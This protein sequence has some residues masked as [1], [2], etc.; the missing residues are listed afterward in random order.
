MNK[1]PRKVANRVREIVWN[2]ADHLRWETLT[3]QDRSRIYEDWML[4]ERIGVEL[5][6]YTD[7]A[8]I[9][10]YLKDTL[11]KTYML[12][13]LQSFEHIRKHLTIDNDEVEKKSYIKPHGRLMKDGRI[14]CW[15]PSS[16]WKSI[17]FSVYERS[18]VEKNSTP[19][20]AVLLNPVGKWREPFHQKMV[21]D[22]GK[23][24]GIYHISWMDE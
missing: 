2:E 24:L 10:V 18:Y 21:E 5:S 19:F 7:R 1:I 15:G 20:A 16:N 17:L 23:R 8:S 14:I 11:I 9:R 4:D 3:D 13:R 12:E 6:N 22:A